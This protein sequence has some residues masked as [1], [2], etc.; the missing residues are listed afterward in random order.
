MKRD[1]FIKI[2]YEKEF[3]REL[4]LEYFYRLASKNRIVIDK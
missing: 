1:I 3:S 2:Q 4:R